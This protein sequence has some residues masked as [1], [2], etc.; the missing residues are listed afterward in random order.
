MNMQSDSITINVAQGYS[1]Q[2]NIVNGNLG[3][4]VPLGTGAPGIAF[5]PGTGAGQ[6]TQECETIFTIPPSGSVSINLHT[7]AVTGSVTATLVNGSGLT[8]ALQ[9]G[10]KLIEVDLIGG[11]GGA[12]SVGLFAGSAN[13]WTGLLGSSTAPIR[14][15]SGGQVGGGYRAMAGDSIGYPVSAALANLIIGN[16][17]SSNTATVTTFFAGV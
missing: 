6:V 10:L 12:S 2:D 7:G 4:R 1:G 3:A 15:G 5:N 13:G 11:T 17:D 16:E 9:A 8:F 14:N